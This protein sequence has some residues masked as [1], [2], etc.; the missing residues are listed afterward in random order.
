MNVYEE[1]IRIFLERLDRRDL[2]VLKEILEND[3]LIELTKQ[4]LDN[5]S[6]KL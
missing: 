3:K 5:N 6:Y 2:G 4:I 1:G